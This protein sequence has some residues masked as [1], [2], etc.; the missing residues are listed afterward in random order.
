MHHLVWA[1]IC[2]AVLAG[3]LFSWMLSCNKPGG[4]DD[5]DDTWEGGDD[6]GEDCCDGGDDTSWDDDSWAD[7]DTP[8]DDDAVD[9]PHPPVLSNGLWYPKTVRLSE[10][11]GQTGLWWNSILAWSVCDTG[12]DLLPEGEL[13]FYQSGTHS[14]FFS[15]DNPMPWTDFNDPP[16]I[17]LSNVANCEAPVRTGIPV[18]FG[19]EGSP[20]PAG[21]YCT[22]IEATSNLGGFSNRLEEIC[23]TMPK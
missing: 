2:L 21:D 11:A 6:C 23:V 14:W 15:G 22:D 17:D 3:G 10:V 20:P 19:E 4:G 12:N 18:L 1:S 5:D 9:D 13:Y 16:E 8:Y 7:D